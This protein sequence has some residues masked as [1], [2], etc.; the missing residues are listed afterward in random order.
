MLKRSASYTEG[1]RFAPSLDDTADKD[2]TK[3][4]PMM[5]EMLTGDAREERPEA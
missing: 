5:K 2:E 4:K 3:M 1:L